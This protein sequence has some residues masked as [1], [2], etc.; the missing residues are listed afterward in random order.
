MSFL[1]TTTIPAP[2]KLKSC[3]FCDGK[4]IFHTFDTY[5]GQSKCGF[6]FYVKCAKCDTIAPSSKVFEFCIVLMEN[7]EIRITK[8]DRKE[9]AD[10]WNKRGGEG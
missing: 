4:A 5:Y 9:A 7:G 8:D 3:P 1:T 10:V 2:D 6:H